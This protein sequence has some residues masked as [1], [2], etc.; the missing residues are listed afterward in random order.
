MR[1]RWRLLLMFNLLALSSCIPTPTP[2]PTP[3]LW[4]GVTPI[5][6]ILAR[7]DA[8]QGRRVTVVAYYRGWDLFAETGYGPPV[9]RSD[10]AVADATGAIYIVSGPD[11]RWPE[12]TSPLPPHRPPATERLLRLE[13]T[14]KLTPSGQP[15]IEVTRGEVVEGL[16][17]GIVLRIRRTGGIVGLDQELMVM[18][19]GASYYLDRKS[20][21]HSR[22]ELDAAQ[23][24]GTLEKLKALPH[25]EEFGNPVPDCFIYSIIFL[26]KGDF[27]EV[28]FYDVD[29]PPEAAEVL[30]GIRAWF[31]EKPK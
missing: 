29:L 5:G 23:V 8:F 19:D 7:P 13:G 11:T 4:D 1:L 20:R 31:E 25:K 30:R 14:V 6:Q 17:A 2:I 21:R 18:Q 28:R 22:F 16:P 15:Y 12:D 24:E 9:T 10:V 3:P 27:R 26:D